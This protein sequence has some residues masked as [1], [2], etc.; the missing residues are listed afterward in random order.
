MSN[1]EQFK[2]KF[3]G[4]DGKANISECV[5]NGNVSVYSFDFSWNSGTEYATV[6]WSFPIKDMPYIW[7]P[8]YAESTVSILPDW[9]PYRS[10]LISTQ[11]PIIVLYNGNNV[12]RYSWAL[13]E[14]SNLLLI[15]TGAS[16]ETGRLI[17]KIKIPVK[18]YTNKNEISFKLRVD[19]TEVRLEKA[20]SAINKWWENDIGL[21]PSYVPEDAKKSAYSFWYSY[22]QFLTDKIIEE[23]CKKAKELGFDVCIVDDGWQTDDVSRGYAFCGDW[24]VAENKIAD[25]KAHV[26]K[27][28][29]IGMK[30]II[31]YAVPL[32]GKYSKHYEQFKN[33]LYP[34]ECNGGYCLDP[35][36]K[37]VRE[38][39]VGVYKDALIKYD[40]DGFKLD[41]IDM[42]RYSENA[43]YNEKM[44]IGGIADAVD[45]LMT[46]IKQSLTEIKKDILIEFRQSYI[47][48]NIKKYGNMFRVGDCPYDYIRN[49]K[50][51]LNL[52]L[53]M[54][55]QPVHS[56]MLMWHKDEEPEVAA[57]Q[58][59]NVLFAVLQYSARLNSITEPM[60]KM[61]K[62]WLDFMKNHRDV[63]LSGELSVYEPFLHYTWAKSTMGDEC[64][65]AVYSALKCVEPDNVK[66]IYIV[67]GCESEQILFKLNGKYD[68]EIKN[69][70]G[71]II[72]TTSVNSQNG[73]SVLNVPVG[74]IVK[75]EKHK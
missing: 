2:I 56:D 51:S 40:Y 49:R 28:H 60:K 6:E 66:K 53:L 44:D 26:K 35:R 32:L 71:E 23:E 36:Y 21:K 11:A 58:I 54:G 1:S 45:T 22:H 64:I 15:K 67:N 16:E 5:V 7:S 62:F 37:E 70:Y 61:S 27:V 3:Q 30:Y 9:H 17:N 20:V 24:E 18:Q 69:C 29:D 10:S 39:L 34:G 4:G 31:W 74:G 47:G 41:F 14:C 8:L 48:P 46:D 43:V 19:K 68:A 63:L 38:Y 59:I 52:R 65:T 12:S 33:M 72:E 42:W 25:M 73:I 55:N 75:L 13:S 57:I 50:E